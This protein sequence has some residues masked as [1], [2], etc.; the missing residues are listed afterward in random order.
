MATQ[1]GVTEHLKSWMEADSMQGAAKAAWDCAEEFDG[2]YEESAK[3][4]LGRT[5]DLMLLLSAY[6]AGKRKGAEVEAAKHQPQQ[7]TLEV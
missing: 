1:R 5:P 6:A 4:L 2:L 7:Q 3:N